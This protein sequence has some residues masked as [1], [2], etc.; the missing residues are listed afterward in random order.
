[1][2]PPR[3]LPAALPRT[4]LA[5][6]LGA[7]LVFSPAP[8]AA[9]EAAAQKRNST[10]ANVEKSKKSAGPAKADW[11]LLFDG[12]TTNGWKAFNKEADAPTGWQVEDGVLTTPGGQG[13][14][15]TRDRYENFELDLEWKIA[16]KG[17]SGIMFRVVDNGP[18]RRTYETGPEYQLIDDQNYPAQLKDVQKT[19]AN[20]DLQPAARAVSKPAG[21]WNHTRIV[22][23]QNRVQH[24]LNGVKVVEY[25][26]GSDAWRQQVQGSKFASLPGYAKA[27]RGHIALQDHGDRV[28]F[29]NIKIRE[30]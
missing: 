20:Y 18:Y 2:Q 26:I 9:Q 27:P 3:N 16:P 11:K 29:R 21:E 15:V 12:K 23:Q 1:M 19:A 6:L 24:W 5:L 30:M 7:A 10:K 4:G 14:I 17:N 28:W 22:V 25:E 8:V 13:D